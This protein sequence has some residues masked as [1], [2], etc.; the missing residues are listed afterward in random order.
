MPSGD[1]RCDAKAEAQ[2]GAAEEGALDEA[3]ARGRP[4][5]APGA[6]QRT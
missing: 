4:V 1:G 3:W 5:D 2:S 6:I